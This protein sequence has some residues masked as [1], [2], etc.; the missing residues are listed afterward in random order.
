MPLKG[1]IMEKVVF[2]CEH[3]SA[4]SLI[5]AE[6]FTRIAAARGIDLQGI[7]AGLDP[8]AEVPAP[9]ISGMA[10]NGID[11]SHLE[12]ASITADTFTDAPIVVH[13]GCDISA[14]IPE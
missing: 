6:Y 5:A 3:G 2:V 1:S 4:K 12:P 13:F 9:V 14:K 8:Y 11:V 10:A 7:Y